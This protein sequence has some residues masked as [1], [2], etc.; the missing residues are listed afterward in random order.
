MENLISVRVPLFFTE[1]SKMSEVCRTFKEGQS[2]M[3]IV[4]ESSEAA[5]DNRNLADQLSSC[6]STGNTFEVSKETIQKLASK[7]IL[8]ILTMENVI[9]KILQIDIKDE[10]DTEIVRQSLKRSMVGN[11]T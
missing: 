3:G 2:H 11:R 6:L 9:E 8:G 5:R 4:C 1:N 10:K 7:K